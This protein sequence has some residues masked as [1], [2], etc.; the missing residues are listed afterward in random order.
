MGDLKKLL[1]VHARVMAVSVG[2]LLSISFCYIG[3]VAR[4]PYIN[5]IIL[6]FHCTSPPRTSNV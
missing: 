6:N 2:K 3:D 1:E 5:G 4:C